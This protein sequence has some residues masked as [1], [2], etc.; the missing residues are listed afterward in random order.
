MFVAKHD[1]ENY[2]VS[3][4]NIFRNIDNETN[5]EDIKTTKDNY[6]Q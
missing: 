2:D 5:A 3:E 6:Q 4:L 1:K